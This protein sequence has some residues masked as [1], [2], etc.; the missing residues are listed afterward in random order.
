VLSPPLA[1]ATATNQKSPS[2][3]IITT[4]TKTIAASPQ[5]LIFHVIRSLGLH[6][7]L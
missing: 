1:N 5:K 3:F 7:E 6:H 4:K 2:K